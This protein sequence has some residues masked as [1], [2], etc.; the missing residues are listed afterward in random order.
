MASVAP[1]RGGR[2]DKIEAILSVLY[3]SL[4]SVIQF[5]RGFVL[6]SEASSTA[7]HLAFPSATWYYSGSNEPLT[8]YNLN[9]LALRMNLS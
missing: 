6:A 3:T 5:A 2:H 9:F 8:T 4:R 7:V 1:A